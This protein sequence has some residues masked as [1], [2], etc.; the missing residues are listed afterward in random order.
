MVVDRQGQGL[1]VSERDASEI[2]PSLFN[3][4]VWDLGTGLHKHLQRPATPD[5]DGDLRIEIR[6]DVG[7]EAHC[8]DHLLLCTQPSFGG[9]DGELFA[10]AFDV[11]DGCV[12][13]CIPDVQGLILCSQAYWDVAKVQLTSNEGAFGLID[14]AL[15]LDVDAVAISDLEHQ[16]LLL[17]IAFSFFLTSW[18]EGH[19]HALGRAGCHLVL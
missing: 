16:E 17:N 2:E 1:G 5:V 19:L 12:P 3:L 10:V 15:A 13:H 7:D 6:F 9:T 4:D 8:E 11:E 18:A 14:D